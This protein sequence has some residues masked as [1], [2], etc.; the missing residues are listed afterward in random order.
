MTRE[1]RPGRREDGYDAGAK[2]RR[3][4]LPVMPGLGPGI[5]AFILLRRGKTWMA[6][7]G[8]AMTWRGTAKTTTP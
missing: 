2:D 7:T 1:G 4:T 6:G 8:P 5:H 3:D